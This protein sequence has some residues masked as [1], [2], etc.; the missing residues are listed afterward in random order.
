[1]R[2]QGGHGAGPQGDARRAE[3]VS[4]APGRQQIGIGG[5][6]NP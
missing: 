5:R 4:R 2:L 3:R 6:G 1:V